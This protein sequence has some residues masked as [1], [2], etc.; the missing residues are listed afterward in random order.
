MAPSSP[1]QYSLNE[2]EIWILKKTKRYVNNKLCRANTYFI[3]TKHFSITLCA[4]AI[5]LQT[6]S[7]HPSRCA[8]NSLFKD[9]IFLLNTRAKMNLRSRGTDHLHPKAIRQ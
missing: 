6:K 7:N 5:C 2:Q 8:T 3:L 4:P 1:D 9:T